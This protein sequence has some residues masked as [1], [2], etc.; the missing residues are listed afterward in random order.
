MENI[1][2]T[3]TEP[4]DRAIIHWLFEEAMAYQR[5]KGYP[6]WQG[7]DKKQLQDEMEKGLQYKI[8]I[9]GSLACIFSVCYADAVIWGERET[10]DSIYLHRIVV[11]P[12]FKGLKL[13]GQVLD[14]AICHAL[15]WGRQY[16]RMDTWAD[17]PNII[18]YYLGFGFQFVG[19]CTT[20][21]TEELAKH[22]R[23]QDLALLE[24]EL[25][26]PEKPANKKTQHAAHQ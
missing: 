11:N 17:N 21:D 7:F 19:N 15:D 9:D 18:N 3:H 24:M 16:V 6:V 4:A 25:Q 14:W 13:F 20:P 2:I 5:R 12:D 8:V 23:N 10:G 22:Y 1:K 26:K